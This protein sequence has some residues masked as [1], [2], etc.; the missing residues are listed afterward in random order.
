MYVLERLAEVDMCEQE[1]KDGI[2]KAMS[3]NEKIS[4]W[5]EKY[6]AGNNTL[7][8]GHQEQQLKF[9]VDYDQNLSNIIR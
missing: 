1:L 3:E 9:Y 8:G 6:I 7:R 2:C 4:A 5:M